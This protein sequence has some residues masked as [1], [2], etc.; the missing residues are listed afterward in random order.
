MFPRLVQEEDQQA[1]LSQRVTG[2]TEHTIEVNFL[3]RHPFLA[4]RFT[5]DVAKKLPRA[6]RNETDNEGHMMDVATASDIASLRE[7]IEWCDASLCTC[8]PNAEPASR[9]I[10]TAPLAPPSTRTCHSIRAIMSTPM[11]QQ[12]A[13]YS[14]TLVN[15]FTFFEDGMFKYCPPC[16][17][18]S[19]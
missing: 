13:E 17:A 3:R 1:Q 18:P 2:Q 4:P 5:V 14:N 9:H 10:A 7:A 19:E 6:S 12:N 11:S 16:L 15:I 8:S